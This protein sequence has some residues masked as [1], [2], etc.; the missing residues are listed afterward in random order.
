MA[1]HGTAALA[2]WWD[3]AEEHRK[4]FE[5][6]HS[7]EHFPERLGLP[8]FLRASRWL[9]ADGGE[10][11][12]VVYELRDRGALSSPEYLARLNAPTPWSTKMMPFHRNMR[13]AQC[14]IQESCGGVTG[15]NVMTLRFEHAPANRDEP[16]RKAWRALAAN[17]CTNEGV[18]GVH[19][20]W[21]ES[22]PIAQTAEQRIRGGD[23]VAD[24]IAVISAYDVAAMDRAEAKVRLPEMVNQLGLA[25]GFEAERF[26]LSYSAVPS[27]VVDVD[28]ADTDK[29]V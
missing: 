1:M 28:M 13:R 25:G 23:Q 19:L 15:A 17:L 2:M 22:P 3:M 12:F 29:P 26:R 6:W 4:A 20:L 5:H 7:H 27:D 10:R 11:V 16:M 21:H 8:G 24:W 9:A 18:A 14:H